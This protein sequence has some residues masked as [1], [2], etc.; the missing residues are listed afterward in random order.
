MEDEHKTQE[1]E[2]PKLH[3]EI[4]TSLISNNSEMRVNVCIGTGTVAL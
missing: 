3:N 4:Q 2:V 1:C